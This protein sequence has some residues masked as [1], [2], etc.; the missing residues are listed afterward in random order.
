MTI[1]LQLGSG[2]MF[3]AEAPAREPATSH[4]TTAKFNGVRQSPPPV[5]CPKVPAP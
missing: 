5:T 3:C 4:D 1:R 2:V